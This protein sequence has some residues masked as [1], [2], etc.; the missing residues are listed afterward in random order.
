M[1]KGQGAFARLRRALG[2]LAG[3]LLAR[4]PALR[5]LAMRAFF[6][7]CKR[8]TPPSGLNVLF[9][10]G[11]GD[12]FDGDVRAICEAL[13][14]G[15]AYANMDLVVAMTPAARGK[16][17]DFFVAT[18][19]A[20]AT[21]V[22][23]DGYVKNLARAKYWVTDGPLP[24]YAK[25]GKE[26]IWIFTS[27]SGA[28]ENALN[29]NAFGSAQNGGKE[30]RLAARRATH[31][32]V[33]AP[34]FAADAVARL[35]LAGK[36]ANKVRAFAPVQALRYIGGSRRDLFKWKMDAGVPLGQGAVLPDVADKAAAA[37]LAAL[38]TERGGCA[39]SPSGADI[40]AQ[41]AAS[42]AVVTDS[43]PHAVAAA[44]LGK[45]VVLFAP[46]G[47][48]A[49]FARFA[50]AMPHSTAQTAQDAAALALRLAGG[51]MDI[52]PE[53]KAE[54][55]WLQQQAGETDADAVA[56]ALRAMLAPQA[57]STAR[58]RR[59]AA[60]QEFFNHVSVHTCG[61]LRGVGFSFSPNVKK[62]RALKNT[63][64]GRRCVLVGNGPSLTAGDLEAIKNEVTFGCN[65]IFKSFEFTAWRPDYY[66]VID[67][68]YIKNHSTELADVLDM[69]V[70]TVAQRLHLWKKRPKNLMWSYLYKDDRYRPFCNPPKGVDLQKS[71]VMVLMIE[72][73]VYMGFSEI[74]L[75]GVD[76]SNTHAAAGATHFMD[77][78]F[79]QKTQRVIQ[80]RSANFSKN[81]MTM[82]GLGQMVLDHSLLAYAG[83]WEYAARRGVRIFNATRGGFLEVF[84][85]ADLDDVLRRVGRGPEEN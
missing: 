20:R 18:P 80:K 13:A 74:Y 58:Q 4:F 67:S 44:R 45:P 50:A 34:V 8:V 3:R 72:M 39:M 51:K 47:A 12:A 10:C 5:P 7:Y 25:P 1:I 57:A 64:M 82:E 56:E 38:V 66:F 84:P 15:G 41:F 40:Y 52:L 62:L 53:V 65:M 33:D 9:Q 85:R 73:A 48:N 6:W 78:N 19:Q 42:D 76:A 14:A 59:H 37:E 79:S 55:T 16:N 11:D 2:A 70:F 21:M 17:D 49:A 36:A 68:A 30:M 71:T 60:R 26:H 23:T 61:A 69:P 81:A 63:H 32:L 46:R 22:G 43:A 54:M 75:I 83:L 24:A 35:G 31:I 29:K 28:G 27:Q 77:N